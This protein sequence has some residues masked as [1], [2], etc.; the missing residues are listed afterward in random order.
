MEAMPDGGTIK[1][2]LSS[3]LGATPKIVRIE[4]ID[5]GPGIPE[6]LRSRILDPYFTTK[7][8]GTGMGLA[9][10]DKI[11]RQHHGISRFSQ[12]RRRLGL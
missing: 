9:L 3:D 5:S 2:R 11:V 1:I 10:C 6:N 7:S 8:E 4:M 12:Y